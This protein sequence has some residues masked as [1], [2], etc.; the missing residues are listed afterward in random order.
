M[1]TS[2]AVKRKA[3]QMGLERG[4]PDLLIFEPRPPYAGLAIELKRARG[5]SATSEQVEWVQRLRARGW[6]ASVEYGSAAA[7]RRV[8]SYLDSAKRPQYPFVGDTLDYIRC[9][10]LLSAAEDASS[11]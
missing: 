11:D 1:E 6:Q 5:C 9:R 10:R 4:V 8:R 7:L 3:K 2:A